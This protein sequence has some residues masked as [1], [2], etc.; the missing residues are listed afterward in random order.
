MQDARTRCDEALPLYQQVGDPLGQANC[1]LGLGEVALR[2]SLYADARIRINEALALY[3]QVGDPRGEA[4]CFF[5]LGNIAREQ[6]DAVLAV[7][8]Y[9]KALPLY[10]QARDRRGEANCMKNLAFTA[11][12]LVMIVTP[13]KVSSEMRWKYIRRS[14][15]CIQ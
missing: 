14:L 6:S 10:Q 5:N 13:L 4:N 15:S 12:S 9:E 3:R 8:N 1:I 2:L 11:L 7:T